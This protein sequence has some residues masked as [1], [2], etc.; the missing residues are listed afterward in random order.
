MNTTTLTS[1]AQSPPRARIRTRD[2]LWVLFFAII[3][4]VVTLKVLTGNYIS[5]NIFFSVYSVAITLYIFSRFLLA[6]LH[7]SVPIAKNF[8]PSIAFV[9]PAKN[10]EDNIYETIKRFGEVDYPKDKIEVIAINDG[11]TDGTGDEMRRAARDI[12]DKVA[13]VEVVDWKDNRGKRHGMHEGT[14]RARHD[15]IIFI[16]SDSFIEKT[17]VR[18]LVKYFTDP[19]IGAVSGHTDVYNRD[20]NLLT[21][22]QSLRY[23]VS[24][25]V[26]KSAESVF[27]AVTCSPGC[28]SAY[29][30]DYLTEFI[31][32]WL[33]QTFLGAA[34]TFGDDRALTNYILQKYKAVYS[35][36]AKAYTVV[37]DNFRQYLKQQQ[38]WK[39]S[40]VRETFLAS[41][42][43]WRRHP[44]AAPFFYLY[45][46][47][48]FVAP[49]VF[50]Y[51]VIVNPILFG[52]IPFV[53]FGGLFLMLLLHG[54]YYRI[55][56]DEPNWIYAVFGF[57]L[58]SIILMWQLPWAVV[59]VTDTSW[60]TR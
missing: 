6:Y 49:L 51:A 58:Y 60:G 17:T 28:C 47:L 48:A 46:L 50:I 57:W 5:R 42:F 41:G 22:M 23:Y 14:I 54:T 45:F 15:V 29:R 16:D 24:F 43:M 44:W 13:R 27:G 37:P 20:T 35:L 34:C 30:R 4:A 19:R 2:S 52:V 39:K 26:Y 12:G 55:Y 31:D 36:E 25:R 56:V 38:R 18:H 9:V 32:E 3:Y 8:E 33:H 11:S 59:T 10:E 21:K 40:W 53:Y 7:R 1:S